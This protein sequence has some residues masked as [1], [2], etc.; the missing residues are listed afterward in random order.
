MHDERSE[1]G[2]VTCRQSALRS[3]P[4]FTFVEVGRLRTLD[5][6]GNSLQDVTQRSLAGLH[7]HLEAVK[8]D[9]NELTTLD[10]CVFYRFD[11]IDFLKVGDVVQPQICI[12]YSIF[13]TCQSN[14]S[15]GRG[16]DRLPN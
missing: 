4:D 1:C 14:T 12:K 2:G 10:H 13:I 9:S 6:S 3:I 11:S 15:K 16:H 7:A 5:L 8:L